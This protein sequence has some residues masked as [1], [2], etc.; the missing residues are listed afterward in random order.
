[1]NDLDDKSYSID[2][3]LKEICEKLNRN[4]SEIYVKSND[5]IGYIKMSWNFTT[6]IQE[7]IGYQ[8][9]GISPWSS[10][11]QIITDCYL[12]L[13][14][15]TKNNNA[16]DPSKKRVESLMILHDKILEYMIKKI[17]SKQPGDIGKYLRS[18]IPQLDDS[19]EEY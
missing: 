3:Q 14:T 6:M 1:V 10:V 11:E 2:K 18:N 13:I 19:K 12:D 8:G 4:W 17:D 15:D 5:D 7:G 16:K 9:E